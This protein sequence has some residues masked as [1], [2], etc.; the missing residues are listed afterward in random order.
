MIE[1]SEFIDALTLANYEVLSGVPCSN[2]SSVFSA[3][4]S[5]QKLRYIPATTE[6]EAIGIAAGHW[7]TGK[8]AAVICQNSGIG[9]MVNPLA[10][11]NEPYGIPASLFVSMRGAPGFTDES[12]H[13]IMGREAAKLLELLTVKTSIL[14]D[15]KKQLTLALSQANDEIFN[16]RIFAFLINP[17]VINNSKVI[18]CE[19]TSGIQ[20]NH[21]SIRVVNQ[22]E[23][24]TR[25][26]AI[27]ILMQSFKNCATIATTGY[28]YREL[29]ATGDRPNY[30]YMVGSMGHA[31]SIGLGI[32]SNLASPVVIL[33]GDGALLMKMGSCATIGRQ[34]PKNLLHI[35]LDNGQ[36]E[37]TG[38]QST[39]AGLVEFS[40][41]A[42]ACNY[43]QVWKCIG[44]S[45]I[46]QFSQTID[47]MSGPTFAHIIVSPSTGPAVAR[48]K[49]DLQQLALRFRDFAMRSHLDLK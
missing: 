16:R 26:T 6:G 8:K 44:Q 34:A 37:S 3:L 42:K 5:T 28:A 30:F 31:A 36:F 12:Q 39:N 45:A 24:V 49:I 20:N 10:S 32:A 14:P 17:K 21:S 22:G 19:P 23:M 13:N 4:E 9:N 11:L 47:P 15:N 27:N 2:I 18:K 29:Y 38:G 43:R 33:D 40:Q 25:N 48:P 7:L 1:P 41:I 46:E 35:V